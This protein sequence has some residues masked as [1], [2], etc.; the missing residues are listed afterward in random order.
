MTYH[1]ET[2]LSA[3]AELKYRADREA[4]I[5]AFTKFRRH[6]WLTPA[7]VEI[8]DRKIARLIESRITDCRPGCASC[9]Q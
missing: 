7:N 8:L 2:D 4:D 5:V 6:P 9:E 1:I 3:L